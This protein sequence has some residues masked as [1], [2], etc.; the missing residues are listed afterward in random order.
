MV[1]TRIT[2]KNTLTI[3]AEFRKLIPAGQE[4]AVSLD[5]QGRLVITPVEK[6]RA[7][8]EES[9]GMWAD[10]EDIPLDGTRYVRD[11]RRGYRVDTIRDGGDETDWHGHCH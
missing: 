5:R 2:P 3:P 11:I 8:L 9:F 4:V 7:A 10:R 6:I 1:V